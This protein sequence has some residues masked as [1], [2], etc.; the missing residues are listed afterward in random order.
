MAALLASLLG[1][2]DA[3]PGFG[4]DDEPAMQIAERTDMAYD[5]RV[6][7][8]KVS[9]HKT[10]DCKDCHAPHTRTGSP[11]VYGDKPAVCT[12]CHQKEAKA[13][14]AG[15]HAKR[16]RG[17]PA[18]RCTE[19]HG[20]HDIFAGDDPRSWLHKLRVPATCGRCH[21]NPELAR[22]LGL[23][24]SA[25][26]Q[27]AESVHGRAVLKGGLMLAPS[28]VD[29]H[30]THDIRRTN[31]PTSKVNRRHVVTTCGDCHEGILHR[32]AQDLHGKLL[33]TGK[34]NAPTCSSCHSA[35][36]IQ[37]TEPKYKLETDLRCGKCHAGELASHLTSFHGRAHALGSHD[38]AACYDC[39]GHHELAPVA[40]VRSPVSAGR[41]LDTCRQCHE[42]APAAFAAYWAHGDWRDRKH[43]PL[44]YWT[45]VSI[46]SALS[47]VFALVGLHGLAW[48]LRR[49]LSRSRTAAAREEG[50]ETARRLHGV[51]RLT[52]VVMLIV[53]GILLVTGVPL[54]YPL[55][56]ASHQIFAVV[57]APVVRGL[58]RV[59][60]VV[61]LLTAGAHA[62]RV[63]G[64]RRGA[65]GPGS[66]LPGMRDVRA[67]WEHSKWFAGRGPEPKFEGFRY[68]ERF[69]YAAAWL[70]F[71]VIAAS[72]AI[73]WKAETFALVV[74]GWI[75]NVAQ[76]VHGEA[77]PFL[78]IG[79]LTF[80]AL[81]A[82]LGK[83]R[84]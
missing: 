15:I 69:A 72:G 4:G 44:L 11:G 77:A 22:H 20:A 1:G 66:P 52:Y 70:A 63:L 65:R 31:D 53:V 8:I 59:A 54:K 80:H 47:G 24:P 32:F 18:A 6:E 82:L 19:C 10:L 71:V 55:S 27:Y 29:C 76:A 49:G 42:N 78:V 33:A 68:W 58:H 79:L 35:H 16:V 60:A 56:D 5:V 73:L 3:V 26:N 12:A 57:D 43:Y 40:D 25:P 83:R 28:C 23:D 45:R 37:E 46:T 7:T 61:M 67:L 9:V 41:K 48:S 75:I 21:K 13:H 81:H 36:Q 38:V 74:P 39:H 51:D 62:F 14:G 50:V 30:G 2:C 17:E 84:K 34:P 64:R